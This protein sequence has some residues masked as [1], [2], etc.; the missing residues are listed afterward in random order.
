[1]GGIGAPLAYWNEASLDHSQAIALGRIGRARDGEAAFRR[2]AERLSRAHWLR[3][4]HARLV[5][6]A[7]IADRW[8]DPVGWL[9]Q[10][11]PVLESAGHDRVVAAC[12]ALLPHGRRA[13]APQGPGRVQ[14]PARSP[15][16]GRDQPGDGRAA[17]GGRRPAESGDRGSPVP[18]P[19]H[20]RDWI[21]FHL[22]EE[23]AR[24][25][26]HLDIL[27]ELA[28]GVTGT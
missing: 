6:E 25:N 15:V 28:D 19:P 21:L 17:P 12:K 27:R 11:L 16:A 13:A 18:L 4:L 1:L 8:G 20:G 5:A 3:C 7:A 22:V 10:A 23:T 26:G 14:G 9:R 24:H 2:A